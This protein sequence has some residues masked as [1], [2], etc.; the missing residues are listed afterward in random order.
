MRQFLILSIK[1]QVNLDLILEIPNKKHYPSFYHWYI[2]IC[3]F[4]DAARAKWISNDLNL[5][6]EGDRLVALCTK[7]GDHRNNER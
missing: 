6:E 7:D 5:E 4:S 3:Q 2:L 1:L